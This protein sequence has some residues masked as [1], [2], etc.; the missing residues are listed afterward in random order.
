MTMRYFVNGVKA[1][2]AQYAAAAAGV[3]KAMVCVD[4]EEE[5]A[6]REA[7]AKEEAERVKCKVCGK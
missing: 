6:A 3:S 7:A 4:S 5:I 1:T 2:A